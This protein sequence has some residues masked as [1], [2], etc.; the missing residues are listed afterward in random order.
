MHAQT[1]TIIA[2]PKKKKMLS[3]PF[4]NLS[5][6]SQEI[7]HCRQTMNP[8]AIYKKCKQT[9]HMLYAFFLFFQP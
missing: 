9:I 1:R 4:N 2:G 3:F 5:G 6:A 7:D 8:Y